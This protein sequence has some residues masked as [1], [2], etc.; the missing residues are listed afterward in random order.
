VRRERGGAAVVLGALSPRTRNAQVALYQSGE[1][2]YLVATDA[3]G[4]GLNMDIDHVCFAGLSKFDGQQVRRLT[5]A[6]L[7]QIAGRAGRFR[8]DGTFGTLST[9]EALEPDEVAA[10]E[11]HRLAPVTQVVWRNSE[12]DKSSLPALLRSLRLRPRSGIYKPLER[13]DDSDAIEALARDPAVAALAC[14]PDRVALLWEVASVPDYQQTLE[15]SHLRLLT[16]LYRQ[17][18]D[19]PLRPDWLHDQMNRLDRPEGEIDALT[20]RIAFVRTWTTITHRKGWVEG[21]S[22]RGPPLRRPAPAAALALRRQPQ[23]GADRRSA[24]GRAATG[25]R[26][27]RWCGAGRRSVGGRPVG[28]Y[29]LAGRPGPHRRPPPP[30]RCPGRPLRRSARPPGPDAGHRRPG[31]LCG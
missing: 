31:L 18:L 13:A 25:R 21:P 30:G 16:S 19:G 12:L 7:A 14:R 11:A 23:R 28:L 9:G 17:L 29:L 6:E 27:G 1:V 2:N 22:D 3:I 26:G 15:G 20:T 10:I 5:P 4:M 8:R 24:R